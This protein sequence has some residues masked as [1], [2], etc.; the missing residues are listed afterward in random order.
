MS[1][2][3]A[4][5]AD[6]T[7]LRFP[8]GTADNIVDTT[9][10]SYLADPANQVATAPKE[11][12]PV[13]PTGPEGAPIPPVLKAPEAKP[14][15]WAGTG[16]EQTFGEYLKSGQAGTFIRGALSSDTG[17][18]SKAKN[19]V[20][21]KYG[22]EILKQP[23]AFSKAFHEEY[24]AL[25]ERN[26]QVDKSKEAETPGIIESLSAFGKQAIEDP[27]GTAKTLIYDLGKDPEYLINFGGEAISI[28]EQA[29]KAATI[30]QKALQVG[31]GVAKTGAVGAVGSTA[32]QL[33]QMGLGERESIN[34]Q[35]VANQAASFAALHLA[36]ETLIRS[37]KAAKDQFKKSTAP[38]ES[39]VTP[40]EPSVTPEETPTAQPV[41]PEVKEPSRMAPESSSH[42]SQ[43][44]LDE[45]HGKDVELDG[46]QFEE[47]VKPIGPPR[48]TEE[49][50]AQLA[51]LDKINAKNRKIHNMP[52]PELQAM[53][54][55]G[56][57]QWSDEYIK[58]LE[59]KEKI[60]NA[61]D[62][63]IALGKENAQ[64]LYDQ[65]NPTYNY[66][67]KDGV[68]VTFKEEGKVFDL[69][70][71]DDETQVG[72]DIHLDYI[73]SAKKGK[74]LASK[75]LDRIIKKADDNDLSISLQVNQQE[76]HGLT[77][78]QLK[79][80][81]ER[82]GFIF[83]RGSDFGYRP[84]PNEVLNGYPEK[85]IQV[86][87]DKIPEIENEINDR[88][89]YKAH[90][91]KSTLFGQYEDGKLKPG[92]HHDGE[93]I[94]YYDGKNKPVRVDNLK[95]DIDWKKSHI[96]V[97][98]VGAKEE[99]NPK[100]LYS[101]PMGE[102][103]EYHVL[104]NDQ[105]Y[106]ANLYDKD[107]EK[108]ISGSGRIF[109]EK[110]FGIHAETAAKNF[111]KFEQ[112]KAAPYSPEI[113]PK[114]EPTGPITETEKEFTPVG[115]RL[116]TA[117]DAE[118]LGAESK[119]ALEQ[120]LAEQEA[121]KDK[122]LKREAREEKFKVPPTQT[123]SARLVELKGIAKTQKGDMLG[124][125][126]KVEGY[127]HV[128]K[129]NGGDLL[130]MVKDGLLDDYLPPNLR[131]KYSYE[132]PSYD[133]RDAYNYI[134]DLM[135]TGEKVHHFDYEMAKLQHENMVYEKN[136]AKQYMEPNEAAQAA[137]AEIQGKIYMSEGAIKGGLTKDT[138]E[139]ALRIDLGEEG[140][141]L[142]KNEKIAVVNNVAELP[143]SLRS[144][145]SPNTRAFYDPLTDKSYIIADRVM[146]NEIRPMALH[147]VGVHYGIK[148]MLGE[149]GYQNALT[150]VERLKNTDPVI[151]KAY[152][153]VLRYDK[154]QSIIDKPKTSA[155]LEEVLAHI[156]ETA[157]KH[158]LWKRILQQVRTFLVKNGIFKKLSLK[159]LQGLVV[160]SLRH[161]ANEEKTLARITPNEKIVTSEKPN[162][163][164]VKKVAGWTDD[165]V[166]KLIRYGTY[167]GTN[168]EKYAREYAVMM[169]PDEFL[170]LTTNQEM[171]ET[172]E[173]EASELGPLNI[174]TMKDYD[175]PMYIKLKG[176][177]T[178]EVEG[179]WGGEVDTAHNAI[180]VN[181]HEGRHRAI[182][183]KRAGVEKIPV[184]L[185]PE[186]GGQV[187]REIIR[188]AK[189]IP[190]YEGGKEF[191]AKNI[192]PINR[193]HEAELKNMLGESNIKYSERPTT[194][195]PRNFKGQEVE[196]QWHGPEESK[197]DDWLYKLQDKHIDTK[198]VQQIITKAGHDIEDN[199]NVYE[200][201]MLY[202]GR[203]ASG[204]RNF[205]LKEVLPAV[206]SMQRLK[207]TP[208]EIHEYLL[209]RHAEERNN[210]MNKINPDVYD[211]KTNRTIANPLKDK[212]SG[213][214]TD[215]ARRYLADL[216]PVKKQHLEEVARYFDEMKKGTQEILVASGAETRD[217]INKWNQT[218]QHYVPLNRV[219]DS[220]SKIPGMVGTGQGLSSRGAFSKR[221]MGSLKEHQ[222]ILGNLIAQRERAIIRSE[223]IR[224]GRALYGL[225]I[226]SP[227]P[228]FWLP[229]NPDA[230]KSRKQ[231]VAELTRLGIQDADQVV[232]NLMAEPKERYLKQVKQAEGI[233]PEEN[234]DFDSGLPVSESKEVVGS[235]VNV[236]ARYNE[237]VFPVRINGKDRFIFFNMN[238]PRAM[239]MAQS[240]KN[241]DVE[242]LGTIE[243]IAG[244]YTR[245][246]KNVNTQYNPVFGLKN[247]VRDY[248][249]GNLNLTNTPIAGKQLQI[250][251]DMMPAM[252]GI[253][254]VHRAERKGVTDIST[255]WGKFYQRMRDEGFQTGYRDSLVRNQ[256]EMQII[257]H[258]LEQLNKKGL[259]ENAKAAL[260][261]VAGALTDFNDIMENSIRLAAAKAALDKGLSP[262]KAAVIAKNITVNFDKKGAKTREIG[263]L[264]AFFNPAVQG[265]ERI[266]QTLK[267]PAG[268]AIIFG[269]IL[270]G[271]IQ[272]VMMEA[273]GYDENDP[274][275]FTREKSFVL[276]MPDGHYIPIP[277]PQGY[278]ILP[279]VG[280]QVMDFMIHGGKNPGKHISNLT[281]AMMDSLSPLG[282]VGWTMQSIAPT[283]LDPLAALA[284]NTDA[285]GRPISRKDRETAPTPGYSRSRD[286]ASTLGKGI[287]EFLNY[288]SGGD[289]YIKGAAS[290]TGDQVDF[291]AGQV[292]GGLYR[293]VS[294]AVQY[295]KSKV[296]GEDL[297]AYRV[298]I[299]GQFHGQ[300]GQ[301]AAVA[302]KFYENVTRMTDHEN[303]IKGLRKD[304]LPK[305]E[306]MAKHP[307][308]KLWNRANGVENEINALNKQKR[309][310]IANNKPKE[311]IQ[312]IEDKKIRAMQ[313][314]NDEV[315]RLNPD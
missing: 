43:A 51:P 180:K 112:E 163:D 129:D 305:E 46:T 204:I 143:E 151:K 89:Q 91:D 157:P 301:P 16:P 271:M 121:A 275:E 105:G 299:V 3:V 92:Y 97:S 19:A 154:Y 315:K 8:A 175:L 116:I 289:K 86:S 283:V 189:L 228:D 261:K 59:P 236:M 141:N 44:M 47:E 310:A 125:T 62:M 183:L 162:D 259:T 2:I 265:T 77:D 240:L 126:G 182:L 88:S 216:D 171:M 193:L 150:S 146:A 93:E 220:V 214:H 260:Y 85:T 230:I 1:D 149:A 186:G 172:L 254:E 207:V 196:S 140:S 192:I 304:K 302:N 241:L 142:L 235:K 36:G 138:A 181:G 250:T 40:T 29:K 123:L 14:L 173:K 239:R 75:E 218:Y 229:I 67:N 203:T 293:E 278:N 210:Q 311:V 231:A 147:E 232:T 176:P 120:N 237:N 38:P 276:P 277:Y 178:Y 53:A 179:Q 145:T 158:P 109:P 87:N 257:N 95:T 152:G 247:F 71:G 148:K 251:R 20:V 291:L 64:Q 111:V 253:M 287:A 6:G 132:N 11:Q 96:N 34:A 131:A 13:A 266:Y 42:D 80:W 128:F 233:E 166:E 79:H 76:K 167:H 263:A 248:S 267:G 224:V 144:Q 58:S 61:K 100:I 174:D 188:V 209:N 194:P 56:I 161:A 82:K 246:F 108:Y 312:R 169:T 222:D 114:K 21:G 45:L 201:E 212:G 225:A 223:K 94:Y 115:G 252:R 139:E 198:R 165:R 103:T 294:K 213:I 156:G 226:Q 28:A 290:P 54:D 81:Y 242:E 52:T 39:R 32:E 133:A 197:I 31:K 200:K 205:L 191:V 18:V 7:E 202:H 288:A 270:A 98:K 107:A 78:E 164:Q 217:T 313:K 281:A 234:F 314:F 264:Y 135:K 221:A 184:V 24:S 84:R 23:D 101:A 124:E 298:P 41:A 238:D 168:S 190:Q 269:G 4:K 187:N 33:G 206:K 199:W 110:T 90:S 9:V 72:S 249:S 102:N 243:T 25:K 274:P 83:P 256:E 12:V 30:G 69:I 137:A 134:S 27:L 262:Q 296:T 284:E 130:T 300:V 5:L 211:A 153:D 48:L 136:L 272:A 74:G 60:S 273:A 22:E 155:F 70:P 306:Y 307:E 66:T 117:A 118:K 159:E 26:K 308:A 282:T 17:D 292:G 177:R 55:K 57:I 297:P 279:N 35:E 244:H 170:G 160:D 68:E 295:V 119:K 37:V 10:K 127:D 73:G 50:K 49:E 227:N 208:E 195:P 15:N 309:D 286:T 280:R 285:F 268:K 122:Q 65:M 63:A 185:M 113:K 104:K 215:D 303:T 106:I 255:D 245:W 99:A 258:L 219:E